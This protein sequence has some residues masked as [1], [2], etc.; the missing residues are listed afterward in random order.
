MK[1][2]SLPCTDSA[3]CIN[4]SLNNIHGSAMKNHLP[5]TDA[6]LNCGFSLTILSDEEIKTSLLPIIC[7]L[8][9]EHSA[10]I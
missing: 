7:Q 10:S 9:E 5:N 3:T 2:A 1:L 8:A 4:I 6:S